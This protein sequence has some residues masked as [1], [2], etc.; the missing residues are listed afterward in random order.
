MRTAGKAGVRPQ[1]ELA[2]P[3]T[4]CEQ[5]RRLSAAPRIEHPS[6]RGV[7]PG[8]PPH[9]IA[10]YFPAVHLILDAPLWVG[11]DETRLSGMVGNCAFVAKVHFA[12]SAMPPFGQPVVWA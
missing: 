7:K 3:W 1:A 8:V 10:D 2:C 4:V 5:Y 11:V 9:R 6:S 12:V